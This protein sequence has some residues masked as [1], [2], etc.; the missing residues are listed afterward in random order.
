MSNQ[1]S[2]CDDPSPDDREYLLVKASGANAGV[3]G[4]PVASAGATCIKKDSTYDV[5]LSD[6]LIPDGSSTINIQVCNGKLYAVNSWIEFTNPS[7]I[8]KIT[9]ISGNILTLKNQCP[10]GSELEENPPIS[11]VIAK[12][13]PFVVCGKPPCE[14]DYESK[15]AE[16][17]ADVQ[18]ICVPS[19]GATSM[20]AI[21]H[22]V[23][24]VQSDPSNLSVGKCIRRIFGV[25]FKAGR[26]F[27][28]AMGAPIDLNDLSGYRRLVRKNDTG[29]VYTAKNFWEYVG[30][31]AKERYA[32]SIDSTR[33]RV[34]GP[35]FLAQMWHMVVEENTAN[36]N[37][38]TWP[39]FSNSLEKDYDLGGYDKIQ[40]I[41][42]TRE[43]YYVLVRLEV[44][45]QKTGS[46]EI[47]QAYLNGKQCG[48]V[49][50]GSGA[51]YL[52]QFN[53]STTPIRVNKSDDKLTVKFLANGTVKLYYKVHIEA[54]YM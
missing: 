46:T 26:P 5:S 12:N 52:T 50:A 45:A 34:T 14:I 11:T 38:S 49:F 21:V 53:M 41:D 33:E 22:P 7:A 3:C 47:V 39:S 40:A 48:R 32:L 30:I 16:A 54:I 29:G 42:N 51:M 20:T 35:I 31:V 15:L 43:Y 28:S 10:D 6:F 9:A 13:T 18:E 44:G 23:G 2:G 1:C 27:L 8:L 24:A 37:P 4:T 36:D 25:L 19:L 17:L